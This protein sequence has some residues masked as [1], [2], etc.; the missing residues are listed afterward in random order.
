MGVDQYAELEMLIDDF[1][2]QTELIID[3]LIDYI[4]DKFNNAPN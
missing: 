2:T 4:N 1:E 3:K